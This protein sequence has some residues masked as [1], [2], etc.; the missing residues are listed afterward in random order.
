[1]L[2][3]KDFVRQRLMV[4]ADEIFGL[5]ERTMASYK[6]E[7]SRLREENERQRQQLEALSKSRNLLLVEGVQQLIGLREECAPQPQED[8]QPPHVK[9]EEEE[10][11]ITQ[12]GEC[13]LGPDE[14]DLTKLPL[15]VVSV[16]TE[17]REDKSPESSR[18]HHS[19]GEENGE[20][21][22]PEV[23]R[24]RRGG[25]QLDKL[26]APL[27]DSD[28]VDDE[29]GDDTRESASSDTDCEGDMRTNAGNKRPEC[30][31]K[32]TGKKGDVLRGN[33]NCGDGRYN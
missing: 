4:A 23:D 2:C 12:E 27:S 29:D 17:D 25:S 22:P 19:P 30:S 18:F 1:M 5:F 6:E 10:L 3:T 31:K 33:S 7:L 11:W 24:D 14:A 32:K 13:L 20:A 8:P 28:E 26:L 21:E 9:E 16:K 15:T